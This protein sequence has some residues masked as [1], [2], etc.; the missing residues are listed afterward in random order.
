MLKLITK[1][2]FI[3]SS[4]SKGWEF[5]SVNHNSIYKTSE[6]NVLILLH[7][8]LNKAYFEQFYFCFHTFSASK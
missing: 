5:W 6:S 1:V 3:L 7:Q 2:M 8:F 4:I